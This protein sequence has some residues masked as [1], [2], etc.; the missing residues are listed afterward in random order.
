MET[1]TD[2]LGS[3]KDSLGRA[4]VL[5]RV[6]ESPAVALH[7]ICLPIKGSL[8]I[9]RSAEK[10][11]VFIDDQR[12]S[13]AHLKFT[14]SRNHLA[15][16]EDLGSKNGT[17]VNGRRIK[18]QS[19]LEEGD[20]VRAGSTFFVLTLATLERSVEDLSK[21]LVGDSKSFKEVVS[22]LKQGADSDVPVLLMGETGTGKEVMAALAHRNSG[23]S[24]S[25]VPVN[26]A[27]IPDELIDSM[28][29]GH[30]KGAFTGAD[31]SRAGFFREADGGTLFLDE[32][33]DLPLEVQPRLLRALESGEIMPVGASRPTYVKVR[34]V[35]ATNVDLEEAVENGRFRPD[36][37]ARLSGWVVELPPLRERRDDI[38]RLARFFRGDIHQSDGEMPWD[39]DLVEALMLY[40]WPYNVRELRQIV[41]QLK[42][43][44]N[45]DFFTFETLPNK[46]TRAYDEL[47]EGG[48]LVPKK[49]P[50]KRGFGIEGGECHTM[51][52]TPIAGGRRPNTPKRDELL[53]VL[54]QNDHN[55]SAVARI[56]QRD[57]K[58][59]YRWM[60][61]HGIVLEDD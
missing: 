26:C 24:R 32:I 6:V 14:N 44:N 59:V 48:P 22:R 30:E 57:R 40:H 43:G 5:V 2:P 37:F 15:M 45:D 33:G 47:R 31:R 50:R 13:R 3:K 4:Q 61:R 55:V 27:A 1:I 23:R 19:A 9:G 54:E 58:Q 29:F 18:E 51:S 10:A 49:T 46:I 39:P 52:D 8:T 16:V 36:L 7:N 17:F 12:I 38:L 56:Y 42:V 28:L 25:F 11:D 34:V 53:Q 35:A 21:G 60:K 41:E 20:V